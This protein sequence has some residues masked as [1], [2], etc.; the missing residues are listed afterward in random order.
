MHFLLMFALDCVM[1]GPH[2]SH[3]DTMEI[4]EV[5]AETDVHC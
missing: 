3:P 5:W 4:A 2:V 1:C